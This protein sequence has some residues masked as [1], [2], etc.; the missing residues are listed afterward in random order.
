MDVNQLQDKLA[1]TIQQFNDSRTS[2]LSIAYQQGGNDAV[3]SLENKYDQL[4]YQYNQMLAVQLD[5]NNAAYG[6]LS[7]RANDEADTLQSSI[8]NL[9]NI[10]NAINS[11]ST[12]ISVVATIVT[13][14]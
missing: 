4:N 11:L 12:V 10:N 1:Q 7:D 2:I 8:A 13:L 6:N 9:T 3:T 5:V 14:V